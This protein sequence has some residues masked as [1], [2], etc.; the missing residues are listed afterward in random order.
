[1]TL[2]HAPASPP[3]PYTTLFR[4]LG[5]NFFEPTVVTDVDSSMNLFQEETFGP[6]LA[7]QTVKGAEEA[8]RHANDS[9]FALAASVWTKDAKK[10]DRKS[11]RLNSSHV[12]ISYAVF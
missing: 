9:P 11:T 1:L 7:M 3:F 10:G 12:S 2:R 8:I 5:P 6:I 4:S